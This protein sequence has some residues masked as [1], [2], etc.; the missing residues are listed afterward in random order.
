MGLALDEPRDGDET[1]TIN[2]LPLVVDPFAL[3][4]I[5]ESGGVAIKTSLFGPMAELEGRGGGGC[6]CS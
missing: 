2:E 3:K 4:L 6:G 5:K 1:Y